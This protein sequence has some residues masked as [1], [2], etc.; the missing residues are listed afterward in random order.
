MHCVG[1]SAVEFIDHPPRRGTCANCLQ[2]FAVPQI[3]H[4]TGAKYFIVMG[5]SSSSFHLS[6]SA[7][8]GGGAGAGHH[9]KIPPLPIPMEKV[10]SIYSTNRQNLLR[11]CRS[12]SGGR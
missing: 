2:Y 12:G 8:G 7:P 11:E 1:I 5:Q 10:L 3:V 9:E 4:L 6:Q